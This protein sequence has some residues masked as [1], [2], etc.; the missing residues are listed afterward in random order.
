MLMTFAAA[1][2]PKT[3]FCTIPG[4][5]LRYERYDPDMER[6]WWTQTTRIDSIQKQSDGSYNIVFTAS[7]KSDKV[8][9]PVKGGVSSTSVVHPDG[10]VDVNISEAMSIAAKQRFSIFDF[11]AEGGI[12]SLKSSIKPGDKL[13][14]IHGAVDWSGI[15]FTLDYTQRSVTVPAYFLIRSDASENGAFLGLGGYY[16]YVYSHSFS[17]DDPLWSVNPHQGGLAANFGVKVA[18][19]VLEWSFRW[20]LNNLFAEQAS[21][22]QNATYLKVSWIF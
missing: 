1:A 16:S 10:T 18:N 6:H 11:Q 8:K 20:Q 14:E 2:Q 13:E 5:T 9:A 21:H 15:K 19:L 7:V 12:S 22:L 17:K 3:Y 4:A